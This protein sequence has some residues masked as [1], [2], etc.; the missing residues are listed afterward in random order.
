MSD[1]FTGRAFSRGVML[2]YCYLIINK[3][4]LM[5][6]WEAVFIPVSGASVF[7]VLIALFFDQQA[8]DFFRFEYV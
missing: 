4:L 7:V 2:L 6:T 1:R 8:G 3:R 5:A